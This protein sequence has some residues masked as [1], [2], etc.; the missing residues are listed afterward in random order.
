MTISHFS[1]TFFLTLFLSIVSLSYAQ[2]FEM[3]ADNSEAIDLS[4]C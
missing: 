2:N 4:K 3:H 1:H